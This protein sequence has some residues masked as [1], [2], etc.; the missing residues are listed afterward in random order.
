MSRK[1][2]RL[3]FSPHNPVFSLVA[4]P[5]RRALVQHF[6]KNPGDGYP[7]FALTYEFKPIVINQLKAIVM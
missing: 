3:G 5:A 1:V 7:C 2:G 4:L 6:L